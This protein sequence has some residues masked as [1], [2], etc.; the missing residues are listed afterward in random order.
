MNA[1]RVEMALL[2]NCISFIEEGLRKSIDAEDNPKELKFSIFCLV[3]A[4]ELALKELLIREHPVLVFADIDRQHRTVTIEQALLRLKKINRI[5]IDNKDL[6]AISKAG[7]IRN[8][9][10]HF[11][12]EFSLKETKLILAKIL[13]FLTHFCRS[14]LQV[15]LSQSIDDS[16]WLQ[17]INI[18]KFE[19]E[20]MTRAEE[21]FKTESIDVSWNWNCSK[22]NHDAFVHFNNINECYLCGHKENV[23]TCQGCGG[24]YFESEMAAIDWGNMKGRKNIVH[25]CGSCNEER[26]YNDDEILFRIAEDSE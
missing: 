8:E 6:D 12:F 19:T 15:E 16:L 9:I 20:L 17:T 22:C 3:Q 4:V 18:E 5:D 7:K 13:G 14:H 21:R 2:D 1:H 25:Y 10:V 11:S 26:E 24:E 23:I